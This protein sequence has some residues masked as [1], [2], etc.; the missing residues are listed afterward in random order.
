MAPK[1]NYLQFRLRVIYSNISV[2]RIDGADL[3]AQL[4]DVMMPSWRSSPGVQPQADNRRAVHAQ[5]R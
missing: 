1:P 2:E 5:P 4:T 3:P